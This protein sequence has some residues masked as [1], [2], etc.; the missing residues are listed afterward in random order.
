[1]LRVSCFSVYSTWQTLIIAFI[2]LSFC[3]NPNL[4]GTCLC[5]PKVFRCEIFFSKKLVNILR[6]KFQISGL[7]CQKWSFLNNF[8]NIFLNCFHTYTTLCLD[9]NLW[10]TKSIVQKGCG[11]CAL[12]H[13]KESWWA[14]SVQVVRS[15]TN[16]SPF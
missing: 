13:W 12:R 9:F 7:S 1:M 8:I 11:R 15:N 2:F 16:N 4:Y 5:F 14:L 3:T 10:M 6:I